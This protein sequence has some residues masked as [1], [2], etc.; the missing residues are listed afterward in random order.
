MV[1]SRLKNFTLVITSAVLALAAF[2][3]LFEIIATYRYDRWKAEFA[4]NDN[5]YGKLTIPS[6]NE[7][8]M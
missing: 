1:K 6:N 8:L 2:I 3:G 4:E 7:I 5:W